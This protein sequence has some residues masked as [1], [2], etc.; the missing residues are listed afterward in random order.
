M[1]DICKLFIHHQTNNQKEYTSNLKSVMKAAQWKRA[2][3][4]KRQFSKDIKIA[5]MSKR[6]LFTSLIIRKYKVKPGWDTI[7][8]SLCVCTRLCRCM[9]MSVRVYTGVH[10][11]LEFNLRCHSSGNG[12]SLVWELL[13]RLACL[14]RESQDS[15]C[16]CLPGSA[17]RNMLS[18]HHCVYWINK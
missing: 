4:P 2:D 12:V 6:M 13:S 16:L 8:L 5:S 14:V 18:S 11:E 17:I 3:N 9:C 15:N 7:P 10:T 1:G